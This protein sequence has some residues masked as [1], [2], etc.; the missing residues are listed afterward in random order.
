M[1]PPKRTATA[2]KQVTQGLT[3]VVLW[4]ALWLI[5]PRIPYVGKVLHGIL[6]VYGLGQVGI[7]VL[8]F[9]LGV[10]NQGWKGMKQ[11][12]KLLL[13]NLVYDEHSWI[14]GV[15]QGLLRH[16]WEMPQTLIGHAYS[17]FRNAFGG[18]TTIAWLGGDTFVIKENSR[19]ENG[20]SLGNYL[21]INLWETIQG[22]FEAYAKQEPLLLHEFGHSFDS[23]LFGWLYLFVI[24]IPSLY[25][26]MGKGNHSVFWTEKRANRK[27]SRY[28]TKNLAVNWKD[29]EDQ[30]PT[31]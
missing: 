13:G 26:A 6:T 24:G 10:F 18:V 27:V 15:L 12:A 9:F 1:N 21:N 7:G 2:W 23:R 19:H 17:Q 31:A 29:F 8:G 14:K 22:N 5:T 11:S 3:V 25:S 28:A 4:C 16:T 20:I 30:Y